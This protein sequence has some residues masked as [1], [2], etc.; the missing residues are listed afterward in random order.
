MQYY[1]FRYSGRFQIKYSVAINLVEILSFL[2]ARTHND[3]NY[4]TTMLSCRLC[5][6]PHS[7]AVDSMTVVLHLF[8]CFLQVPVDSQDSYGGTHEDSDADFRPAL[9]SPPASESEA[10]AAT[11]NTPLVTASNEATDEEV[12][13]GDKE[14]SPSPAD[15]AK[16]DSA[17]NESQDKN[18]TTEPETATAEADKTP[19]GATADS[20]S[21]PSSPSADGGVTN[22]RDVITSVDS[23]LAVSPDSDVSVFGTFQIQSPTPRIVIVLL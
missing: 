9:H 5:L 22:G 17:S 11:S 1:F 23:G 14:E 21:L 18:L 10:K 12:S 6:H 8:R 19:D 2:L 16:D 13:K 15:E 4:M 7:S 3:S 20:M